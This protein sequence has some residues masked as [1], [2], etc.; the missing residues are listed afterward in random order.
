MT[1]VQECSYE[2]EHVHEFPDDWFFGG[3]DGTDPRADARWRPDTYIYISDR[4]EV[5]HRTQTPFCDDE[6]IDNF[7]TVAGYGAGYKPVYLQVIRSDKTPATL[8]VE[9]DKATDTVWE[10]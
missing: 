5:L 8:S 9:Y 6:A 2:P 4:F 1:L 10:K 7:T 3:P